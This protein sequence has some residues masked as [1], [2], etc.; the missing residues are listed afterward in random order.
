MSISRKWFTLL[1]I[2]SCAWTTSINA[3]ENRLLIT[4]AKVERDSFEF[5]NDFEH[6]TF[7]GFSPGNWTDSWAEATIHSDGV[8]DTDVFLVRG[9]GGSNTT[10][11]ED[12][13]EITRYAGV[14]ISNFQSPT[15]LEVYKQKRDGTPNLESKVTRSGDGSSTRKLTV[16]LEDGRYY[17]VIVKGEPGRY[18]L[19]NGSLLNVQRMKYRDQEIYPTK[20]G[21]VKIEIEDLKY[22]AIE[23]DPALSAI[24]SPGQQFQLALLDPATGNRLREAEQTRRGQRLDL[25]RSEPGSEHIVEVRRR[26]DLAINYGGVATFM[27]RM[28]TIQPVRSSA[29]LV[30]GGDADTAGAKGGD[31][32][33]WRAARGGPA[34][35]LPTI[36][37]PDRIARSNGRFVFAPGRGVDSGLQQIVHFGRDWLEAIDHGRTKATLAARLGGEGERSSAAI[38]RI[39]FLGADGLDLGSPAALSVGARERQIPTLIG[40]ATESVVPAGAIAARIEI[41]FQ[42]DSKGERPMADD[43][44]LTLAEFGD[45]R[46]LRVRDLYALIIR[47][48]HFLTNLFQQLQG[49]SRSGICPVHYCFSGVCVLLSKETRAS[50]LSTR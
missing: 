16:A 8:P 44:R 20:P 27:P 7:F 43:V 9:V 22:F 3:Y 41:L 31:L 21:P 4:A 32:L 29:N 39:T 12:G 6:A 30:I 34:T 33:P 46:I 15:T 40:V 13:I 45:R 18:S 50:P 28:E 26:T 38:G 23:A 19:Y 14:Q 10:S 17:F 47:G 24:V 37:L 1:F 2:C 49:A 11:G 25:A 35:L 36:G 48:T 42:G 5:N